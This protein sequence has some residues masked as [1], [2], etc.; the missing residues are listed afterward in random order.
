MQ[1]EVREGDAYNTGLRADHSTAAT[2]A[3][4]SSTCRNQ[5]RLSA[6]LSR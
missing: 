2:C 5:S 3:S 1:V 4:C 6:N